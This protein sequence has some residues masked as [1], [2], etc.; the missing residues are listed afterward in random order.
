MCQKLGRP[1]VDIG[2][3]KKYKRK[4]LDDLIYRIRIEGKIG[5]AKRKYGLGRIM[6][7][8]KQSSVISIHL[9]FLAMNLDA[10]LRA[11][12]SALLSRAGIFLKLRVFQ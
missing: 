11:L 12:L 1:N 5:V 4:M 6:T 3:N 9:G 8:M 7:K 2:L 10:K